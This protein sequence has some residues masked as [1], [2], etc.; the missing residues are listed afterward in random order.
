MNSHLILIIK[1]MQLA[2]AV[3]DTSV[4]DMTTLAGIHITITPLRDVLSDVPSRNK[5]DVYYW[6]QSHQWLIFISATAF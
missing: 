5:R 3:L 6:L 2:P 1:A 4:T